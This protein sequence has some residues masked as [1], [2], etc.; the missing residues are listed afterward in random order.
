MGFYVKENDCVDVEASNRSTS[1]YLVDRVIP[2]LPERLS[3]NICSLTPNEDKCCFSVIF[4]ISENTS[5]KSSWIGRT[6]INSNNRFTYEQVQHILEGGEGEYKNEL[7]KLNTIAKKVRVKRIKNGAISF[8]KLE[9]KFKLDEDNN[10]INVFF[11]QS[12]DSHK[13][14]EEFMLLANKTVAEFIT[15]PHKRII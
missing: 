13:L 2:M 3:N 10:P 8:D 1:V 12:K 14:V 4:Q 9:V 5:V 7:N 11:K 6:I 15:Y